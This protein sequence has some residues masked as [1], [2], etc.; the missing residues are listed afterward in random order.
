V[1][2]FVENS[3]ALQFFLGI[4]TRAA[5]CTNMV[6]FRCPGRTPDYIR[7]RAL[8]AQQFVPLINRRTIANRLC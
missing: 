8:G 1:E 3:H 6:R 2:N 5:V 7:G 4:P